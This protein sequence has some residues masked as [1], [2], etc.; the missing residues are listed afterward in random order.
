[1]G[2]PQDAGADVQSDTLSF[3]VDLKPGEFADLE[4]VALAAIDWAEA[5]KAAAR[6]MDPDHEYR[7]TLVEAKVGSSNWLAKVE[8][9]A[10]TQ[11]LERFSKGWK[12]TP[13]IFRVALGLII[14]W[15]FTVK[16]S[17]EYF[18]QLFGLS[19]ADRAHAESLAEKAGDAPTVDAPRRKMFRTL[20]RDPRITGVGSGV[21]TTPDW[22]PPVMVPSDHFPEAEGLFQIKGPDPEERTL[23]MTLDVWLVSPQLENAPRSWAFRQ[24]GLPTFRAIMRDRRFL[25]ALDQKEVQEQMRTNIPMTIRLEVKQRLENTVWKDKRGGRSVAEVISPKVG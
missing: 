15:P 11:A 12:A 18:A 9:P 5:I 8:K 24:E 25:A 17:V 20:K 10:P 6:V 4:I 2:F 23:G 7:V 16:P 3:Y 1:M 19:D 14:V 13:I 21:P 22:K